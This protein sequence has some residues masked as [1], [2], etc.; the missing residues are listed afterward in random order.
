MRRY[1]GGMQP[2]SAAVPIV[3]GVDVPNFPG[4][5][6]RTAHAYL[7]TATIPEHAVS[8]PARTAATG[9]SSAV[10][11]RGQ[12]W[13]AEGL[14]DAFLLLLIVFAVPAVML[15]LALPFAVLLRV[16]AMTAS[17]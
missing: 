12:H 14:E 15:L 5:T 7:A 2:Y 11:A 17:P 6:P 9:A 1:S 13:A 4:R 3:T 10:A 16:A 8:A